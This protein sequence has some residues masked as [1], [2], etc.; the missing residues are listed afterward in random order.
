MGTTYTVRVPNPPPEITAHELRSIIDTELERVDRSMSGYRAD[1]EIARFNTSQST[2]WFE[3]SEEL[4]QVVIAALEISEQS[5]GAFD[6]TVAPLVRVWGFGPGGEQPPSTPDASVLQA[7]R[8]QIGYRKLHARLQPA[9]LRKDE[10]SLTVDL[11]G[12][13]PGFAVDLIAQRFDEARVQHYMIDIGGEVRMRG[14]SERGDKWRIAV[15]RPVDSEPV[16][17]RIL[18]LTDTSV[19][20]SGE[21]RRF[22]IRD[23]RRYSHTIDPRTGEPVGHALA[24]VV[25]AHPKAAYADAWATAFNVLGATEGAEIAERLRIPAMFLEFEGDEITARSTAGFEELVVE[26]FGS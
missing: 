8:A 7:A 20:T 5:G 25:V 22:Y 19:T 11:N 2:D 14:F 9:A 24:S 3:V 13:A 26:R 4:A 17:F 6:V 16:P 12:I 1:S 18:G 15:E 21:Y 10:P 23:G